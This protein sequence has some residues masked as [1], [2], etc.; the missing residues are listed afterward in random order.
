[1]AI[2]RIT[3]EDKIDSSVN[4][5][6]PKYKITAQDMN[7]IKQVFNESAEDIEFATKNLGD[8][9]VENGVIYF[10]KADGTYNEQGVSLAGQST[11]LDGNGNVILSGNIT[12]NDNLLTNSDFISGIINQKGQTQ[13]VHSSGARTYGID[14]WYVTGGNSSMATNDKFLSINLHNN[15][16]FGCVLNIDKTNEKYLTFTIKRNLIEAQ[17][18]TF[19]VSTMNVAQDYFFDIDENTKLGIYFWDTGSKKAWL[20][21]MRN[22]IFDI[23]YMKLERGQEFT[24][25]PVWNEAD[26][27]LKCYRKYISFY[28]EHVIRIGFVG[29]NELKITYELPIKMDGIPTLNIPKKIAYRIHG[30]N[31]YIEKPITG[32]SIIAMAGN[33]IT[34]SIKAAYGYTIWNSCYVE[35][36]GIAF[37][38]NSY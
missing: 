38:S 8:Y 18:V 15:G 34:V 1:M 21:I 7:E 2:G 33:A 23:A 30:T 9:K 17:S 3:Y 14:C 11:I 6:D 36:M 24:G 27:L 12:P 20:Y 19:D 37:D 29:S 16:N 22:G 25:M 4:E 32:A 5:Q 13:Y 31:D 26:E 28:S 10:K 35:N